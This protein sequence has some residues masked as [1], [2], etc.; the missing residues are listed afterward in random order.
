MDYSCHILY[1]KSLPEVKVRQWVNKDTYKDYTFPLFKDDTIQNILLKIIHYLNLND[2]KLFPY[3]WSDNKPLRFKFSKNTWKGYNVNP[4]LANLKDNPNIPDVQS[5][6]DTIVPFSNINIVT[7]TDFKN[8]KLQIQ[9]YYFPNEKDTFKEN[10]I[11]TAMYEQKLLEKLWLIPPEKH[12]ALISNKVCSYTRAFFTSKVITEDSYR[13][14]FDTLEGFEFI[15]FYNDSNNI[16]YKVKKAHKIPNHL[17]D[18]WRNLEHKK[19]NSIIIYSFIKNSISSY[20]KMI[21]HNSKEVN[22]MYYIDVLENIGY[23]A[24]KAHLDDIVKK[25]KIITEPSVERLAVKTSISIK[26]VNL[27]SLSVA[28]TKLQMIYNV[29]SKNRIQKNILDIQ[30]KRVQKY[31][32]STDITEIIKSKIELGIQVLDIITELQEYGMDEAEVREYIEQILKGEQQKKKKRDFKNIGLLIIITPIA[33]GLNINVNNASSYT[34]IQNALFWIRAT[35][36]N[37]E[38]IKQSSVPTQVFEQQPSP[39]VTTI[40][41]YVHPQ[42]S[43]S[44]S[45]GSELSLGGAIGKKYQRFFNTMLNNIDNDMFAKTPN[46]ATKCGVSA[47]RQPI[48]MTLEEKE[49]IDKLGYSDGYDNFI[50]HGSSPEKQN[51]YMCPRIYCPTSKVPLSYKKYLAN[52]KKCPGQDEEP[53]LLYTT[54]NWHNDPERKHY[55]GFLKDK[56]YNN[57][58]L[59]CCFL[60]E[61]KGLPTSVKDVPKDKKTQNDNY[62][63]DKI[64]QL[65]EGRFGSLPVSL[66]TLLHPKVPHISC[67]N[68]LK[69]KECVLRIGVKQST[70]SLMVSIAYLLEYKTKADLCNYIKEKL[71]PFTF[72][73][74][75][76]GKVYT[77]FMPEKPIIPDTNP[78]KCKLLKNWLEEHTS[79]TK[80]YNLTE[81]IPY[82]THKE[83]IPTNIGFKIARQ[84][85]IHESYNRF[86]EYLCSDEEKNP[87]I[88]FDLIH[89]IGAVL[90]IWNRDNQNIATLRCPYTTKNKEWYNGSKMI[91]YIMV[92]NQENY[93][94]PLIVIDQYNNIKQKISFTHFEKLEKVIATCP[95]MMKYEDKEIQD[96]FTLSKWIE[97]LLTFPKKF[98]LNRV[99]LDP[100]DRAIGCFLANNIYIEFTIPLSTFSLKSL[101]ERCD[102]EHIEYWEDIAHDIYDV[103]INIFD[104]RILQI[105]IKKLGLG[106]NIGSIKEQT[107]IKIVAIYS[108]PGVKYPEPPKV[109]LIIKTTGV[110]TDDSKKWS[111]V[112]KQ[113]A[114]TLV[115]E[116]ETLVTPLLKFSKLTQLHKLFEK[117]KSL[118]EPS[119]V[120]VILEEIPYREEKL[121]QKYYEEVL[122][123]KPYYHKDKIVHENKAKTEWIF[124]QKVPEDLLENIKNPTTIHRPSNAPNK[125]KEKIDNVRIDTNIPL[126]DLLNVEKL[127]LGDLPTKW[128]SKKLKEYKVGTLDTYVPKKSL[129]E[130][131]EWIA[132]IKGVQFDIMDLHFYLKKQITQMLENPSNYELILED[133]T[134]RSMWNEKLKRKYRTSREIID[135]GFKGKSV[136]ELQNIWN[137]IQDYPI[138]DIDLYNISRIFNVNFLILQKGKEIYKA[139]GNLKELVTSSKFIGT[140]WKERPVFIL[141]KYL[142]DDTKYNI[143][144]ILVNKEK[145]I[146]YYH[147][148]KD[149]PTEFSDIIEGHF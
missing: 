98:K 90:I 95:L 91:P 129:L 11:Q 120:A 66:H 6:S 92:M 124:N 135:I 61:Q 128:R 47:L 81:I 35:I 44:S 70:D 97:N 121:L 122:L 58:N 42:F 131:F 96:I 69:S 17:F 132:Q 59:P 85:I 27:K 127:T 111:S 4:F 3:I 14:V 39:P 36:L 30:F 67:K 2:E 76:N 79:Y 133:P 51:V 23:D 7:Y 28:F 24:I 145:I 118:D 38:T 93:Y 54:I 112:K 40:P 75:E 149:V 125:D 21:I 55:V 89:H 62:I 94:E 37:A 138:Q 148:G 101:I 136:I 134:I 130:L 50:V 16:I 29:P 107:D 19:D 106:M 74:L 73:S 142:S 18:E 137:S 86:L 143:Y 99:I 22:V 9:K 26:D 115:S 49:N 140:M 117:F 119:R 116:Y 8:V 33:L 123:D 80:L 78:Q 25:V 100:Q 13:L 147:Y 146:Q 41:E 48:G 103:N 45:S 12:S 71:D 34:E 87:Y 65:Q 84:L 57:V 72:I 114:H 102:I 105:K 110:Y 15:Q 82:L 83:K 52:D 63:I 46:Y 77:Y 5:M 109:P 64:R 53:I 60:N 56:G 32:M 113:I 88:L 68:I 144:N 20:M 104:Y 139:R 10:E 108:V 31:G 126:P 43:D 141:Y 1:P